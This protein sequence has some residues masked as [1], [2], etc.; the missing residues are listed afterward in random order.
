MAAQLEDVAYG[1]VGAL[2]LQHDGHMPDVGHIAHVQDMPR[3]DLTEQCL[4]SEAH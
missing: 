3:G 4:Q 1:L 2:R